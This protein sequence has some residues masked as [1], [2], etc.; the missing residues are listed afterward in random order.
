MKISTKIVLLFV[1]TAGL[2]FSCAAVAGAE[3]LFGVSAET[4][5]TGFSADYSILPDVS[6]NPGIFILTGDLNLF[7]VHITAEYGTAE[8]GPDSIYLAALKAGWEFGPGLLKAKLYGGY[9][10]FGFK[11]DLAHAFGALVASLGVESKL[12]KFKI[13]GDTEIPVVALYTNGITEESNA[14]LSCL[15]AGV[16]F[17]PLPLL[18]VFINYRAITAGS[19]FVALS[20]TGTTYGVR[21]SF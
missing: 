4:G 11:D 19:S 15:N 6:G 10:A 14:A 20:A 21:F 9:R 12:G 16:S 13:Y 1:L 17:A 5:V 7:L 8:L 3:L 18:D 2:L